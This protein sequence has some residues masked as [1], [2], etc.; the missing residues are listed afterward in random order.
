[1]IVDSHFHLGSCRVFGLT[2]TEDQILEAIDRYEID[3][4]VVQPFPGAP[5]AAEVHDRIARLGEST[6]GRVVG[7]ASL[8]P[9]VDR[10]VYEREIR[11]CVEDLGFVGAKLHTLGHAVHP[12]SE[13]A[14]V[15]FDTA[16]SLGIAVMVHTGPGMPFADPA[17]LIERADQYP[18]TPIV[19]AHAGASVSPTTAIAVARQC[20]NVFLEPSWCKASEVRSMVNALGSQRV[21]FGSDTPVNLRVEFAKYEEIGLTDADRTAVFATTAASV[22]RLDLPTGESPR[23]EAI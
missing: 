22:F 23:G 13:D 20:D 21:M 17:F 12:L 8:N 19:L 9:H 2:V 10:Q 11:R 3:R 18:D 14:S 7:L 1:M 15:V 4:I 16:A 5:D 6:G